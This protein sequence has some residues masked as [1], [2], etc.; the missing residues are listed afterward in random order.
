MERSTQDITTIVT[1]ASSETS[2]QPTA[3]GW[4]AQVGGFSEMVLILA[5][6]LAPRPWSRPS[7][8][9]LHC[10]PPFEPLIAALHCHVPHSY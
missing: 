5:S 8:A 10:R 2:R 3:R 1:L 4:L 6:T 7:I 9:A